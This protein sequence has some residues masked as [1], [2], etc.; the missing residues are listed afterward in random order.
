[1]KNT[2][3][4]FA[5]DAN[6]ERA[7]AIVGNLHRMGIT[8][9]VVCHHDGRIFPKVWNSILRC[10]HV[11]LNMYLCIRNSALFYC[12][13]LLLRLLLNYIY[14]SC[15]SSI[16][17]INDVISLF[18]LTKKCFDIFIIMNLKSKM[19]LSLDNKIQIL[20]YGR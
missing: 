19:L 3:T 14:F 13:K 11:L 18:N 7:K 12:R 20:M 9:T 4:I 17:Q 5:N 8:N 6:G 10:T 16:I 2:G 15:S 1:M